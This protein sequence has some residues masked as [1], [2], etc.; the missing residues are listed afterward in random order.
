M[1]ISP[2][3]SLGS[4]DDVLVAGSFALVVPPFA[5][6]VLP[7]LLVSAGL[8]DSG[9]LAALSSAGVGLGLAVSAGEV[10]DAVSRN[11]EISLEAPAHSHVDAYSSLDPAAD[12]SDH[13]SAVLMVAM[14]MLLKK[15]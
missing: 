11:R 8:V 12:I 9:R 13:R 4:T 6:L 15:R 10:S 7:E 3:P 5:A 2:G 14:A 1:T